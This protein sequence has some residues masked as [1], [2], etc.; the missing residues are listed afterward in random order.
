VHR[1]LA[2]RTLLAA[3]GA[4][5]VLVLAEISLRALYAGEVLPRTTVA[6]IAAGGMGETELR[7]RLR[8]AD[9]TRRTVVAFHDDS[10]QRLK[11]RSAGLQ[12]RAGA[13]ARRALNSGRDGFL[14]GAGEA[15]ASLLVS[16]DVAPVL[17]IDRSRLSETVAGLAGR[18]DRDPFPGSL[19]IETGTLE[20]RG[21]PSRPGLRL[22][23]RATASAIKSVFSSR[24]SS[25]L[26]LPVVE[27]AGP[28]ATA[29][30]AGA[31]AARE[32]LRA[33][34][35]LTGHGSP[36]RVRPQTLARVLTLEAVSPTRAEL[37]L[38]PEF[39]QRL[40]DRVALERDRQPREATIAA[41]P[42]VEILS[43]PLDLSWQ[44]RQAE[45][46]TTRAISGRL[47]DRAAAGEAI[48]AAVRDGEHTVELPVKRPAPQVSDAA[49]GQV[50]SL[51]GAFTTFFVCC[52]PRVTNIQRMAAAVDGTLVAPAATFSLNETVGPR[53][54]EK[55][56]LP[57]PFIADG[58]IV[59][60][61]GGG[62]SQFSTTIYNAA[63]FA[64]LK[65]D[66]HQPHSFYIDRYPPGR[67]ATLDYD[68][69]DLL[70]TNDTEAPVLIR[71]QATDTSVSVS[72]YGD[73]GGR[74]VRARSGERL[75]VPGGDFSVTVTREVRYP[76]GRVAEEP[77]TT[78]YDLPPEG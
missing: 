33:P 2:R 40:L 5:I 58:E 24:R 62:V 27:V 42:A 9:P 21:T 23:R 28:S 36:R 29:V 64:G 44:P 14:G 66:S 26:Q 60:S 17:R 1:G 61:V 54:R 76:D 12:L 11:G 35:E 55:G 59:P 30:D 37:G 19:E 72:L 32:Y 73:N 41:P 71:S 16:S 50:R 45:I 25:S 70:W 46:A 4:L 77:F 3:G 52:E 13:T 67:E 43:E 65:L 75:P 74:R 34:L 48:Q 8:T 47:L 78:T 51:I 68:S 56:Y 63:Y 18:V 20:V 10:T 53:T 38:R 7:E 15:I 69:I 57:A 6:G 22:D 39:V 49:A 31:R